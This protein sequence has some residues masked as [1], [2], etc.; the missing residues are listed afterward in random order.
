MGGA[1]RWDKTGSKWLPLTDWV[2]FDDWNYLGIESI[3]PDPKD[4]NK[5]YIAVGT[6]TNSW[7]SMNGQLL[8]S[9]DR[10]D[11][12]DRFNL[13]FKVGGNMPGRSMGER[14]AVDPNKTSVAQRRLGRNLEQSLKFSECW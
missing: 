4:A 7:T 13:P 2:G 11:S 1:Y 10:G 9:S 6:Y 5:V 3:A 12:F 8:R 14:L